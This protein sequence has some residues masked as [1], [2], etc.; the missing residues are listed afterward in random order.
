MGERKQ[1]M[2][3]GCGVGGA[4]LLTRQAAAALGTAQ[5]WIGP[6]DVLDRLQNLPGRREELYLTDP[7]EIRL[8]V[9]SLPYQRLAVLIGGNPGFFNR[10]A[11]LY[12]ALEDLR[13]VI[14]P[15]LS[16]IAYMI[17]RTGVSFDGAVLFDPKRKGSGLVDQVRRHRKV[18]LLSQ[19]EPGRLLKDL[20]A[21]G[22]RGLIAYVG[23][24][25]GTKH[26][27]I[28]RG[29]LAELAD[30]T[31]ASG[32]VLILMRTAPS[33]TRRF[34]IEDET[35]IR[36]SLPMTKSAVRAII[37]SRLMLT[38]EDIVYDIGAGTGSVSVECALA[39]SYGRVYA[40]EKEAEGIELIKKN[41]EKFGLDNIYP[42]Q[43]LAPG[44]L[45]HLPAPDAAFI[46]GSAG[47]MKDLLQV[48]TSRNPT[49]RITAAAVTLETA[50]ETVGY[51]EAMGLN[52]EL[53]QLQVSTAR[54][55][56]GR[57]LM[58]AGNPVYIVSGGAAPKEG[59][60]G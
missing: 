27:R 46:G 18:F 3:V 44:A 42:I 31:Y 45:G 15:G 40:V 43:G 55:A 21:A 33:R 17:A 58:I 35:F 57:H 29:T 54:K 9:E 4:P 11:E 49:V 51:M 12:Q 28:T 5:V 56:G 6:E 41:A 50:T 10:G 38:E 36:G 34:G 19:G 14:V 25:L 24:G 13:P 48:L 16:E 47:H 2:I 60:V 8:K 53:M 20:L 59:G 7:G 37:L 32:S 23:E 39:V 52:P 30:G 26:E 1:I 22:E